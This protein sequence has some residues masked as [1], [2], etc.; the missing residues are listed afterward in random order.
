MTAAKN[1]ENKSGHPLTFLDQQTG[2]AEG[3]SLP[4]PPQADVGISCRQSVQ[5]L[6][7]LKAKN[8]DKLQRQ[9]CTDVNSRV[10]KGFL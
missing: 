1:T 6:A 4:L 8:T 3:P 5:T 10:L 2:A 9:N 7:Q